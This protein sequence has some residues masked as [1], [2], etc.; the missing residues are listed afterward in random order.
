MRSLTIIGLSALLMTCS[1][2]SHKTEFHCFGEPQV[3]TIQS[4]KISGAGESFVPH[5][6]Q[7]KFESYLALNLNYAPF[8]SL[9]EDLQKSYGR[10]KNR[11]EAHVTVVTPPEYDEVLSAFLTMNEINDLASKFEIQKA[12]LNALCIGRGET[13]LNDKTE[14]VYFVVLDSKDLLKLR[15]QIFNAFVAKGGLPSHFDPENFYPH[16]TLGFSL[17]DLHE[18]DGVKKGRN[19]CFSKLKSL[20]N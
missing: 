10:L 17:R 11:A 14:S 18:S 9:Y 16:I 2:E 12:H 1:H 6:G 5:T 4:T 20:S 19:A 15:H 3:F 7:K 13:L 8:A